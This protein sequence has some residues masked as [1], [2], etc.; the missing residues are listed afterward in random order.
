MAK[1]LYTIGYEGATLGEL[2]E[3]LQRHDIELII[4]VREAPVSRRREFSKGALSQALGQKRIDYLH[5]RALGN[6]KPGREAAK[7][8]DGET[9]KRVFSAHLA[10]E[11]AQSALAKVAKLLSDRRAC[12]L[13]LERDHT[14]CHRAIVA[15]TLS[16]RAGVT[17]TEPRR[18]CRRLQSLRGWS[19]D[20]QSR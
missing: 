14:R 3:T 15:D 8:G 13:C 16:T 19:D 11:A 12:L 20:K 10:G 2:L 17:I 4:D 7:R 5:L 1:L 9:Y 18:V 6:P